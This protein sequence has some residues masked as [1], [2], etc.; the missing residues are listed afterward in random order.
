MSRPKII[1]LSQTVW[2]LWPAQDFGIRGAKCSTPIYPYKILINIKESLNAQELGL[3]IYS[4]ACTK[5][6][7]AR[8][9]LLACDIPT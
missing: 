2:E 6:N 4:V 3:E 9:T 5:K 7:K 1:K 8:V